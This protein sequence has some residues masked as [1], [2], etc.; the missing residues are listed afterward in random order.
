MN[1]KR[2]TRIVLFSLILGACSGPAKQEAMGDEEWP[3]LDKFHMSMAEAF[4]PYKDSANL[5]PAKKLA[6]ELA[7]SADAW[8]AEQL[9]AKVNN[10][11]TKALLEALKSDS[12]KLADQVNAGAPN[13]SI[14]ASLTALHNRFHQITEAWH[15]GGEKHEH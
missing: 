3:T 2:S 5:E 7:Q 8:V 9:P 6:P 13:D 15:G 10:D 1:F 12:H 4:H 11:D 14:G